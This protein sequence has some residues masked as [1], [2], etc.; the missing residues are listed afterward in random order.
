LSPNGKT[1]A[2]IISQDGRSELV[3]I[4]EDGNQKVLTDD[5]RVKSAPIWSSDGDYILYLEN[6]PRM[7]GYYLTQEKVVQP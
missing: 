6:S 7:I 3:L 2:A 4:S 5:G 1:Q